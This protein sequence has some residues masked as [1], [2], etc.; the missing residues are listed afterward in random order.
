VRQAA[1]LALDR[2]GMSKALF[3]GKCK[4]TNS[5]IPDSFEY[6]WQPP[7]AVYDPTKAR[8]LLTEAGFPNG[9][10]S[11][12]FYCDSSY[13]NIGEVAV[14]NFH[15]VGIRTKLQPIE[16]AGFAAAYAAKKY[17]RGVLRGASGAFGNAATRLASFVVTGG[18]NVYG[19][20]PDIDALFP[21]QA[22]ELDSGKRA[23]ILEK[24]QRLVH[25]KAIFAPIWLL[26]FLNGVGP[27]VGESSF[28]RIAGFPYTAPF[29]D[30]TIKG[31][32]TLHLPA[33]P[34]KPTEAPITN[35]PCSSCRA[36]LRIARLNCANPTPYRQGVSGRAALVAPHHHQDLPHPRPRSVWGW[37]P[38]NPVEGMGRF[39]VRIAGL[40]F[41]E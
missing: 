19:G 10:D 3:L 11:G 15:E 5:I 41:L 6:Y 33:T 17:T 16:R 40:D 9:F 18:S 2:E 21:Q 23:A 24:M 39:C 37:P 13:A 30:I 4:I 12:L 25:E 29:E 1:N 22:N 31:V 38:R 8:E 14:N 34:G 7:P 20:Y 36:T 32:S 28:G 35:P 27:R 26:A